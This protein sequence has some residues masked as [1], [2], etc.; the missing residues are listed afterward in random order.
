MDRFVAGCTWGF[1]FVVQSRPSPPTTTTLSSPARPLLHYHFLRQAS[2]H[3][4]FNV[5]REQYERRSRTRLYSQL[6][7]DLLLPAAEKTRA[8][9]EYVY[10]DIMAFSR[11][12]LNRDKRL[13]Y[14][15]AELAE[16]R[17]HRYIE[18]PLIYYMDR[19]NILEELQSGSE[20]FYEA[21][22]RMT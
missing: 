2:V 14:P 3:I 9:S 6:L 7:V 13:E 1:A 19:L 17:E 18:H 15:M 20:A 22:M 8:I 11:Y 5:P 21:R 10:G 16:T 12:S 4:P